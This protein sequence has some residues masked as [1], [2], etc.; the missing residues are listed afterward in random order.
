VGANSVHL[1]V[2]SF[3]FSVEISFYSEGRELIGD[4][5]KGP[6]GRVGRG[7]IVSEGNN[8]GRGSVFISFAEGAESACWSL[9][10][11]YEIR[12]P[13]APLGGDDHPSSMNGIFSQFGHRGFF[14]EESTWL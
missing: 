2:N 6:S 8:L 14:S 4:D 12:G 1:I 9:L 10:L 5:A 13:S 7:A 3:A 11:Y